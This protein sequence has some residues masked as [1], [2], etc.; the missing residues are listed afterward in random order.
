ML[1]VLLIFACI[2]LCPHDGAVLDFLRPDP[3]T[4]STYC[5][6]VL[7]VSH[8]K[9]LVNHIDLKPLGSMDFS[10]EL[11]LFHCGLGTWQQFFRSFF[12][13]FYCKQKHVL[14]MLPFR[15]YC[16]LLV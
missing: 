11:E 8:Q 7:N 5:Q 13:L 10:G 16:I 6:E 14:T 3:S 9:D 15:P 12:Y 4:P 1:F 2:L